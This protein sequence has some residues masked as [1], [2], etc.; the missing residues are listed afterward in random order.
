MKARINAEVKTTFPSRK[1]DVA[2]NLELAVVAYWSDRRFKILKGL[3]RNKN[4]R[5]V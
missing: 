3:C 5:L 1:P 2:C 4:T